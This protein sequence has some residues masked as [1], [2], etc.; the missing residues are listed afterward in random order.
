MA[1]RVSVTERMSMTERMSWKEIQE[2]YPEQWVA[3]E[4]VVYINNET[5]FISDEAEKDTYGVGFYNLKET[6]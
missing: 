2:K 5:A 3:L 6:I 1:E 4:D